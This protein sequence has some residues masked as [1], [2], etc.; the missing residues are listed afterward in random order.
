MTI[1][2]IAF[3]QFVRYIFQVFG[4]TENFQSLVDNKA[5]IGHE[6]FSV[7]ST[8]NVIREIVCC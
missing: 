2:D 3:A 8:R 1:Q 6:D 4:V 5:A 7:V